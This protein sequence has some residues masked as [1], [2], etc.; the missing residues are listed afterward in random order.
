MTTLILAPHTDDAEFGCGGTIARYV[1][2]GHH[3]WCVAFSACMLS[4]PERFP[5]DQL[6]T[7]VKAAAQVLGIQPDHL[8]LRDFHVRTFDRHRQEILQEMIRLRER[9]KPH[10]VLLPWTGDVHQDHRVIAEEGIRAFKHCTLLSY[11]LPW[12][13]VE[14]FPADHFVQLHTSHLEKKQAAVACYQS[15]ASRPYAGEHAIAATVHFRGQQCGQ[16][17][18]EAF[19]TVRTINTIHRP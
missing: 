17:K 2:E 8:L 4:V 1:E 7:E 16:E 14:A 15:Q 9:I 10:M 3:V 12:N 11:E 5:A 13:S 6:I 18:A 19:H